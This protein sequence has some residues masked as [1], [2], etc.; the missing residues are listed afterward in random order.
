[1][2]GRWTTLRCLEIQAG[3]SPA[4]GVPRN[5]SPAAGS[6]RSPTPP[7][8]VLQPRDQARS[9]S[10]AGQGAQAGADTSRA[11]RGAGPISEIPQEWKREWN[12]AGQSAGERQLR[13]KEEQQERPKGPGLRASKAGAARACEEKAKELEQLGIDTSGL[14]AQAAQLWADHRASRPITTRLRTAEQRLS[15]AEQDLETAATQ[16]RTAMSL[17]D[18]RQA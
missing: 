8:A 11:W 4:S 18:R 17:Y 16:V 13:V 1:M 7:A 12:S 9:Q 5:A 3:L 6:R 2:G 15:K 10:R 14:R